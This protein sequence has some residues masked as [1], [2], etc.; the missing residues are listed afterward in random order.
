[1]K[2]FIQSIDLGA[3]NAII[4]GPFIA[5]KELKGELLPKECDKMRDGEK[6]VQ[7][8][9]KAKSILT[10]GLSSD[11]FLRTARCKSEKEIWNMLEVTHEGTT[12]VRRARRNTLVFEY[13]AFQM[14]NGETI[15]ELQKRFTHLV[16]HLLGLGKM[17]E[18]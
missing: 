11:E 2:I 14:M 15:S 9:K 18:D 17:F 13:K 10:S 3:W 1:M 8:D 5:T 12:D 7:D 4:K 16:N 6:K